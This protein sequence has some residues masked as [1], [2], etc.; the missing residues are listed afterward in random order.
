LFLGLLKS[1]KIRALNFANRTPEKQKKALLEKWWQ[2][3]G[4]IFCFEGFSLGFEEVEELAPRNCLV[5]L[6]SCSNF[7]TIHEHFIFSLCSTKYY[8]YLNKAVRHER[9]RK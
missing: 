6:L 4:K 3:L 7:I 1:L 5:L 2:V 8:F 9:S